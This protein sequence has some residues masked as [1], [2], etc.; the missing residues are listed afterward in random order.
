MDD[1][2]KGRLLSYIHTLEA[3][4]NG[5]Q[6]E[7]ALLG[8]SEWEDYDGTEYNFA[9]YQYRVRIK[10]V[11]GLRVRKKGADGFTDSELKFNTYD[12]AYDFGV[13]VVTPFNSLYD[14]F[15]VTIGILGYGS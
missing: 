12:D 5:K 14:S 10:T 6:I 9:Y 2:T 4:M 1:M 15:S 3:A 7:R 8:S 11:Y 13:A